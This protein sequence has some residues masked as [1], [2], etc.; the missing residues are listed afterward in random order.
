MNKFSKMKISQMKRKMLFKQKIQKASLYL[1][2]DTN[3]NEMCQF[4]YTNILKQ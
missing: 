4:F 2:K 3:E 1:V